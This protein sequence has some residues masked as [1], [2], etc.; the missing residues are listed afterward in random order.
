MQSPSCM[1]SPTWCVGMGKASRFRE[2]ASARS[3]TSA[4][5]IRMFRRTRGMPDGAALETNPRCRRARPLLQRSSCTRTAARGA[6]VAS[7][8]REKPTSA[9]T[10]APGAVRALPVSCGGARTAKGSYDNEYRGS[11]GRLRPKG[12]PS[13]DDSR[14]SLRDHDPLAGSR[15][16]R[17]RASTP[18]GSGSRSMFLA[19]EGGPDLL[20]RGR[21][22]VVL[23]TGSRGAPGR[24]AVGGPHVSLP[25][26]LFPCRSP[27]DVLRRPGGGGR[28]MRGGW[29][30]SMCEGDVA[31]ARRDRSRPA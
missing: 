13:A 31:S 21:P 28:P 7:N 8:R 18:A 30:G 6:D 24:L 10:H 25:R 23:P 16:R 26:S 11:S 4:S 17:S 15:G 3:R 5:R 1:P 20:R 2:D 27:C 9:R 22:A 19:V 14:A 29:P 12:Y